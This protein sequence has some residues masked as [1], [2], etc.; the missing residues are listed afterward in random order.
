MGSHRKK[1]EPAPRNRTLVWLVAA[2]LVVVALA[3]FRLLRPSTTSPA[4][5]SGSDTTLASQD[6]AQIF[7]TYAGSPSCRDCHLEA[8]NHWTNSHHALAE[9][10]LDPALDR[11]A[12]DPPRFFH[13]G[14]QTSEAR[15]WEGN[16]QVLAV[17][18]DQA[19]RAFLVERV[20]GIE[21]LRQFL[22]PAAGGRFQV[23]E[24]A[25]DPGRDDWFDIFG[26]EDR[27]P[28]E[29]GHWTGRGM[30][31]NMMCAGCHNTRVRKNY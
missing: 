13:H 21:P 18:V 1:A 11:Q 16:F 25:Y 2:G 9:R 24:V 15:L 19:R 20:V 29:W 14:S 23:T 26:E 10:P 6:D 28:G 8:F 3:A 7:A 30:T 31:W 27:K 17:G 5:S 12:F 22:V 4:P